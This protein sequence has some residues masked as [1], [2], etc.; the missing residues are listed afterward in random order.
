MIANE[1]FHFL[2]RLV[3]SLI[4]LERNRFDR[5]RLT[6]IEIFL[7]FDL[8]KISAIQIV[9]LILDFFDYFEHDFHVRISSAQKNVDDDRS[10]DDAKLIHFIFVDD[11]CSLSQLEDFVIELANDLEA[12]HK[13]D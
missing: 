2:R 1:K 3:L 6:S 4:E 8:S 13:Y 12:F 5:V 11:F 10:D 7:R 9:L